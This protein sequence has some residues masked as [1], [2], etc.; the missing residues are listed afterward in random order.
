MD[1]MQEGLNF[2]GLKNAESV[3]LGLYAL[4][5]D[6]KVIERFF[7]ITVETPNSIHWSIVH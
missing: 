3:T 2:L 7:D 6:H 1:E 4:S 5:K